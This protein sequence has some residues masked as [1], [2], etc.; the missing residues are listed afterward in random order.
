[1]IPQVL[2]ELRTNSTLTN[3]IAANQLA[4]AF[5]SVQEMSANVDFLREAYL[6]LREQPELSRSFFDEMIRRHNMAVE[7]PPENSF[8]PGCCCCGIDPYEPERQLQRDM[9]ALELAALSAA[10]ATVTATKPSQNS[11]SFLE[12]VAEYRRTTHERSAS[13]ATTFAKK[14]ATGAGFFS[15]FTS[16]SVISATEAD[17]LYGVLERNECIAEDLFEY[18]FS[19]ARLATLV[20]RP[21]A[22]E[23][24]VVNAV[25]GM[26]STVVAAGGVGV[27]GREGGGCC[28][29]CCCCCCCG[30]GC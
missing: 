26:F 25:K 2:A 16:K 14:M 27:L 13:S 1:M 22:D 7:I 8:I 20:T 10:T 11:I 29:C 3:E 18:G 30:G 5:S 19:G 12:K 6:Y 17:Y 23:S 15:R 24:P 21:E 28:C 4:D 9:S